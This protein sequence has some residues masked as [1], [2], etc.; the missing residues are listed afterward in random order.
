MALIYTGK[1]EDGV[2][3]LACGFIHKLKPFSPYTPP[4]LG[5]GVACVELTLLRGSQR[6]AGLLNC[7]EARRVALNQIEIYVPQKHDPQISAYIDEMGIA[8]KELDLAIQ[9]HRKK[10][11]EQERAGFPTKTEIAQA[12][13]SALLD[14]LIPRGLVPE[15]DDQ[16]KWRG[17]RSELQTM[18]RRSFGY[19]IDDPGKDEQPEARP[20]VRDADDVQE[21]DK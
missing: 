1:N 19:E 15:G 13:I 4:S 21:S 12:S 17:R 8:A 11:L 2:E 18:A 20:E 3:V 16:G 14:W 10:A 6:S 9:E 7:P 5:A